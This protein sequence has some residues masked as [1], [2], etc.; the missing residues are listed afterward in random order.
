VKKV[1]IITLLIL[2]FTLFIK[3]YK[4]GEG[5]LIASTSTYGRGWPMPYLVWDISSWPKGVEGTLTYQ[6]LAHDYSYNNL[7]LPIYS[8]VGLVISFIFWFFAVF[9]L[10]KI[11]TSIKYKSSQHRSIR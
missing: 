1:F 2:L 6:Q 7:F 3:S 11:F 4:P 9:L 5:L 10:T 8:A